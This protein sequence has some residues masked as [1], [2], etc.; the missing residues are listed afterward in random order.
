[1][2]L[3][4]LRS[5]LRSKRVE[6]DDERIYVNSQVIE[7]GLGADDFIRINLD[8]ARGLEYLSKKKVSC[9]VANWL[10]GEITAGTSQRIVIYL[11]DHRLK[12]L[13]G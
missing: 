1:M 3:G 12:L 8:I 2:L 6:K 5:F 7:S 9:S 4:D 10:F 11:L 13:L